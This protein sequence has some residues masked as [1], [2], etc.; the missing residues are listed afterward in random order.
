MIYLLVIVL[1]ICLSLR[2]DI[3]GKTKYRDFWYLMM[4]VV[5]I[6]IAGLRWRLMVDTPNYIYN[7]YH[8]YPSLENFSFEDYPIGKDPFY[9]LINSLV[10]SL[11]GR[12]YVVQL[13]E[14]TVVNVLVFKYI[15]RHSSYL[16][17]CLFFYAI[18]CYMGYSME[19]MRASLSVVICLYAND[20]ILDKKWI[21]GYILLFLALMF[22]AQTIL[23]GIVGVE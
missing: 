10:I 21:K 4:L 12:F 22:H 20:Y 19:T 13:I 1:L 5:F 23:F 18:M 7:F 15:K 9:V 11:G 2:Y 17:T 8:V 14:A 6:L 3:N 16:F